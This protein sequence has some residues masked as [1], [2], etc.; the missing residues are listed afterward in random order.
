MLKILILNNLAFV[1]VVKI[2]R[3]MN[4]ITALL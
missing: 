1:N 3:T 2:L 4:V